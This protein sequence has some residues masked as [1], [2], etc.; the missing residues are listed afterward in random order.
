[1]VCFNI[2][3]DPCLRASHNGGARTP[4]RMT[5]ARS[6]GV[7]THGTSLGSVAWGFCFALSGLF[8]FWDDS[9]PRVVQGLPWATIYRPVGACE[10]STPAINFCEEKNPQPCWGL[11][12]KEV[13]LCGNDIKPHGQETCPSYRLVAVTVT[14]I[15]FRPFRAFCFWVFLLFP[16]AALR[17]PWAIICSPFRADVEAL[18]G[19][20]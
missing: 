15:L 4:L 6:R 14:G 13:H 19:L 5:P 12:S 7:G 8:V 18:R 17:L 3:T 16:R 10:E 9:I 1:M 2:V 11:N 20:F